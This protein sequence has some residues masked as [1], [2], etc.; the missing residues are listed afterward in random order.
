MSVCESLN[1]CVHVCVCVCM[2]ACACAYACVC[3][4]V[5][6]CVIGRKKITV[7][8][9]FVHANKQFTYLGQISGMHVS[10]M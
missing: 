9:I 8:R 6:M 10:H 7:S 3:V 1:F 2:R 4:C 5:S